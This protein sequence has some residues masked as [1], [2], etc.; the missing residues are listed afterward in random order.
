MSN[1]VV[2]A[3]VSTT[4][5]STDLQVDALTVAGAARIFIDHASGATTDRAALISCLEY[6]T[7]GDTLLVGRIDRLGRSITDLI[8]LVSDLSD[9]GIQFLTGNPKLMEIPGWTKCASHRLHPLSLGSSIN[10]APEPPLPHCPAL[11]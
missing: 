8:K 2:Y 10:S 3:R 7:P 9:R 11:N 4:D 5:Q 1:D 6:L